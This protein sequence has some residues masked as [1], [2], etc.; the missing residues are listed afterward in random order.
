M[1]TRFIVVIIFNYTSVKKEKKKKDSVV[2]INHGL[3]THSSINGHLGFFYVLA[4]VNNAAMN[5]SV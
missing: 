3:L 1:V 4:I 5:M 2:C